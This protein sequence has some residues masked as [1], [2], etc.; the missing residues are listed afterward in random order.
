MMTYD[1]F[2]ELV[3]YRRSVRRL[4]PDPIPDEY[5]L[6]ILDAAHYSMSGG[7]SQPWEFIVVKDR[8]VKDRL[9]AAYR[10]DL[11]IMWS[12]EQQ[13]I[14]EYRH[15]AFDVPPEDKEKALS[16][17]GSWK[18]APVCVAVLE[19]P[20]KQWGS[21]LHARSDLYYNSARDILGAT[22]GHLSMLIHLAAASLGLGS[23]RVD[24]SNEHAYKETLGYPEP[25]RLNILVPIGYRAYE[26]G[27]PHRLPLEELI[28]FD[29]YD[30]D[31]F[32]QHDDFLK[33]LERIR[34]LG[35]PGYRVVIREDE[36]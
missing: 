17:L 33:Y 19:D 2:L 6:K 25:L 36:G 3:T 7:N 11:E 30:M 10:E 4:K 23:E 34:S 31:K 24:V 5:V 20:R 18:D 27:P 26:P 35:K 14:R 29:R 32:L 1:D 22:M 15:P 8:E 12:L 9:F 16:M 21:V 28:H 13:R